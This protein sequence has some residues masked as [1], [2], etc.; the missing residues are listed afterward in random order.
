MIFCPTFLNSNISFA[1]RTCRILEGIFA[2][3]LETGKARI[4]G[5][6]ACTHVCYVCVFICM[7]IYVSCHLDCG[8]NVQ[9]YSNAKCCFCVH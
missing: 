9:Q 8:G 7:Y 2:F 5:R 1:A 3:W 4:S 6:H